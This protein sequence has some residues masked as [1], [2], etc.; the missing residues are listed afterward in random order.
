VRITAETQDEAE[1]IIATIWITLERRNI[2]SPKIQIKS[3]LPRVEIELVFGNRIDEDMFSR[4]LKSAR[5][6]HDWDL[7]RRTRRQIPAIPRTHSKNVE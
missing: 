3:L 5:P 7:P 6:R 2:P 1:C 4:E